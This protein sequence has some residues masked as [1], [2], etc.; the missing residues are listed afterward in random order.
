MGCCI[1]RV[2]VLPGMGVPVVDVV[3]TLVVGWFSVVVVCC[4]RGVSVRVL[5]FLC[6]VLVCLV[7]VVSSCP[8]FV[9]LRLRV[10]VVVV[11]IW[12]LGFCCV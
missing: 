12:C 4:V 8:M 3:G 1:V 10:F 9:P 11:R 7:V 5:L 2:G 6:G